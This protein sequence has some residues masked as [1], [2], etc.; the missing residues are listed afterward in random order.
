MSERDPYERPGIRRPATGIAVLRLRRTLALGA[1]LALLTAGVNRLASDLGSWYPASYS[2]EPDFALAPNGRTIVLSTYSRGTTDLF[3]FDL[4]SQRARRLSAD[5]TFERIYCYSPDAKRVVFSRGRTPDAPLDLVEQD[6]RTGQRVWVSQGSAK[7]DG[8]AVFGPQGALYFARSTTFVAPVGGLAGS[9]WKDWQV[10]E[11]DPAGAVRPCKFAGRFQDLDTLFAR[12]ESPLLLASGIRGSTST[13]ET[14]FAFDL[15]S[16]TP[17]AHGVG[18]EAQSF[19]SLSPDGTLLAT[20]SQVTTGGE[21]IILTRMRPAVRRTLQLFRGA[22]VIRDPCFLPGGRELLFLA[23]TTDSWPR[24]FALWR[25]G[26]NQKSP[27]CVLP[28]E[29]VTDPAAWRK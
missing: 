24:R 4:A 1:C 3:E 20:V 17:V 29:A 5:R 8:P 10:Y 11:R 23:C 21:A 25:V 28:E 18:R 2:T 6:L 15:R 9:Q 7:R 12:S 22:A 13:I 26:L 14:V 19:P 16:R 27:L